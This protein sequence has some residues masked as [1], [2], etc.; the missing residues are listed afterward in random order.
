MKQNDE[1]E[2]IQET[3]VRAIKNQNLK[4]LKTEFSKIFIR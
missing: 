3:P 1:N 4:R 2:D